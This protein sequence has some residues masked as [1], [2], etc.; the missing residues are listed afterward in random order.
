MKIIAF[1]FISSILVSCLSTRSNNTLPTLTNTSIEVIDT[2]YLDT[3]ILDTIN[4]Y[5]ET[6]P[7]LITTQADLIILKHCIFNPT[8]DTLEIMVKASAGWVVPSFPK[9]VF[10]NSYFYIS[11]QYLVTNHK[12]VVNTSI[13]VD[14]K[15]KMTEYKS[16]NYLTIRLNGKIE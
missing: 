11:Y 5:F 9:S 10:P 8:S 7:F 4:K 14:F 3:L 6:K 16:T 1:V 13:Y 2:F 12:G 15:E